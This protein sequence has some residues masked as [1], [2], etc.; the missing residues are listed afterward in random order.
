ML[1][2]MEYAKS[3]LQKSFH[4]L[5][6]IISVSKE[7]KEVK[8][9]TGLYLIG[10]TMLTHCMQHLPDQTMIGKKKW[11]NILLT[12]YSSLALTNL[13]ASISLLIFASGTG[14][15]QL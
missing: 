6:C 11:D 2:S 1:L 15:M 13:V 14:Y 4:L 10:G 8:Q 12:T 3:S 7:T 5:F 9:S